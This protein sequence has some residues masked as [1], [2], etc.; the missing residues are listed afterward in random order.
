MMIYEIIKSDCSYFQ[1]SCG[2]M[3]SPYQSSAL[4]RHPNDIILSQGL[5]MFTLYDLYT[6]KNI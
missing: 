6:Q 4:T 5:C 1:E 3:S 2:F